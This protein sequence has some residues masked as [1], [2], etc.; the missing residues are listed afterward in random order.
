[1]QTAAFLRRHDVSGDKKAEAI[2]LLKAAANH[3]GAV[4]VKAL[5]QLAAQLS[6]FDGPFDKLKSMIQ[7]MIFRL[8]DEQRDEDEHKNWCDLE[9]ERSTDTKEDKDTKITSFTDKLEEMKG[10]VKKLIK[11]VKEN[12]EKVVKLTNHMKK[13]KEIR[14]RNH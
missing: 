14:I 2:Q 7:K 4:H 11:D 9:V 6:T 8:M 12:D 3:T 5:N 1:M 13:E 10:K